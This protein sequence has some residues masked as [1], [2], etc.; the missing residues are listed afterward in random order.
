MGTG[1]PGY[2]SAP[3]QLFQALHRLQEP[4][5]PPG[6]PAGSVHKQCCPQRQTRAQWVWEALGPPLRGSGPHAALWTLRLSEF[7]RGLTLPAASAAPTPRLP[8]PRRPTPLTSPIL[9]LPIC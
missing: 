1:R 2:S 9:S 3:S 5:A 6:L 4:L 7:P 8:S